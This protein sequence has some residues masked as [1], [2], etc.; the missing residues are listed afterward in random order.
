MEN[1]KIEKHINNSL[2]IVEKKNNDKA[3]SV[4]D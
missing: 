3:K 2:H 1:Y 4:K